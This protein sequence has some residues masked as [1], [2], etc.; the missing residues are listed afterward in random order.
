MFIIFSSFF[1][2]LGLFFTAK[3]KRILW[4][5]YFFAAAIPSSSAFE[6]MVS[7]FGVYYYEPFIFIVGM[8]YLLKKPRNLLNKEFGVQLLI[9]LVLVVYL[10]IGAAIYG[11]DKYLVREV[12]L[13]LCIA[14]PLLMLPAVQK[15]KFTDNEIGKIVII[16]SIFHFFA[17]YA[18]SNN[19][20]SVANVYYSE[21]N[22][23]RYSGFSTY[24]CAA[25]IIFSGTNT[26]KFTKNIIF[27]IANILALSVILIA[28]S[29]I[30]MLGL[31]LSLMF[32]SITNLK[33]FICAVVVGL[34]VGVI[35]VY[36]AHLLN[37]DRLNS[38]F[39]LE[40]IVDQ[41]VIRLSPATNILERAGVIQAVLG[42]ALGVTFEIPWFEYQNLDTKHNTIDSAYLTLWVKIG[43][44]ALLYVYALI[45]MA[46]FGQSARTRKAI[47]VFLFIIMITTSIPY[48][49]LFFVFTLFMLTL[50]RVGYG[51]N[52]SSHAN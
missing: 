3:P 17:F 51:R 24:L 25:F 48:Q 50:S 14:L 2:F 35:F 45:K 40:G 8:I 33:R 12:R 29:R 30:M 43:V 47:Y 20:I 1:S 44:F 46:A 11:V 4:L 13:I 27:Y 39:S 31:V 5:F 49:P 37:V 21:E 34:F 26:E 41:V 52:E 15:V 38:T 10:A 9:I 6:K 36:M 22:Q 32:A 42:H 28:G 16:A 19:M 18:F 7:N 23:Y